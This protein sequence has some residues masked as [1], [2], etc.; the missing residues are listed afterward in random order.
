MLACSPPSP[1]PPRGRG[2]AARNLLHRN[3]PFHLGQEGRTSLNLSVS[4]VR[5]KVV[6]IRDVGFRLKMGMVKSYQESSA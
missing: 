1:P 5:Q 2:L 4:T 6:E 3:G